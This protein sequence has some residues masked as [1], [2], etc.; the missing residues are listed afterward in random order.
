MIRHYFKIAFRNLWKYKSQ[1]LISVVGLAVGFACFA[2]ATLWIRYEMTFDSFHKN[3]DRLYRVSFKDASIGNPDGM[4][5]YTN[6]NLAS[7]LKNTFPE[8]NNTT[9][10]F[11]PRNFN[12]ANEIEIDNVKIPANIFR[13]DSSFI[14]FFDIRI[15][16]GNNDFLI[17]DR[18]KNN[19]LAITQ[20]KAR[21]LFGDENPVGKT[22]KLGWISLQEYTVGA[23][24]AEFSKHSNYSFDIL[25]AYED[26]HIHGTVIVELVPGVDVESLKKKLYEHKAVLEYIMGHTYE[27]GVYT[28][29]IFTKEME[30]ISLLPLTS[31]HYKDPFIKRSVKFQHIIIF[32]VAGSLLILCTLLNYL[33]LFLSRFRMR[34]R[35]LAL[36][37]VCGASNRSL[38][39][40]LSVEF[41]MSLGIALMLGLFLIWII[42]PPF[43]TLSEVDIE[44]SFIYFESMIYIAAIIV[45]SMALFLLILSIFRRRT[46]NVTIRKGNGKMFRKA[47]VIVQLVISIVF[48]FCT[49][50][51]LKQ[52][53][54]LHNTEE[55]G[56]EFKNRGRVS[57]LQ[58]SNVVNDLIKQIPEITESFAGS[59]IEFNGSSEVADWEGK[60]V[61]T[62]PVRVN[63]VMFSEALLDFYKFKLIA[64]EILNET[65]G[66][67][68]VLINESAAKVFG[69]HVSE[70]VGK[71]LKSNTQHNQ[72]TV[73][74]DGRS[75]T[76]VEI[77]TTNY[78]VKGLIKNVYHN[79][80]TIPVNPVIYRYYRGSRPNSVLFKYREGT[81]KT[82]RE[83]ID[84]LIQTKYPETINITKMM[85]IFNLEEEY[86]K[87]LKSE[88]TLLWILS[89]ISIVCIAVCVLGFV[90]MVSLTCEERRKEI[91]IRKIHGATIKD[92]LDIFFK[93]YLT[94]L[95]IGALIAFPTGY[96]I[97]KDWLTNYVIQTEISAWVYVAIL[98]ALIMV[99]ILCVGGRVYKTSRENPVEAINK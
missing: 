38:F 83:K 80:P 88:N 49:T 63:H 16:E 77:S 44:L 47:S 69:W 28:P 10:L 39:A 55:L 7:Y 3:A 64:G 32:A 13:V 36:R 30:G 97:M 27:N 91:A 5:A 19:Q 72:I 61:D 81:W 79:T 21:Q 26:N 4:S 48:A 82:C 33:T 23:V 59:A 86:D 94:L 74:Q 92:I 93:E 53:Y 78:T 71:T 65:D 6:T 8:I 24:V 67:N 75:E 46:L 51:I 42:I 99:I 40:L 1:T 35:E 37:I 57:L 70:I 54:Y 34:M 66:E 90:S 95:A 11:D 73:Y 96:I 18:N 52:M 76:S 56:F 50:I 98:L 68:Y 58:E 22:V 85:G 31:I 87:L 89:L 2:I 43:R 45:F 62:N 25:T 29:Y 9:Q 15:I 12:T 41:L 14:K 20:K 84:N 60:S 17:Y